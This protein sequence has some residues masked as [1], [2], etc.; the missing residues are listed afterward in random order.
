MRQGHRRALSTVRQ[1][2]RLFVLRDRV[3]KFAGS[4][5]AEAQ[6][7]VLRPIVSVQK[8]ASPAC[9]NQFRVIA[10]QIIC[11]GFGPGRTETVVQ[12]V[13]FRDLCKSFVPPANE[14][15]KDGAILMRAAVT[16][17]QSN[18]TAELSVGSVEIPVKLPTQQA[19]GVVGFADAVVQFQRFGYRLLSRLVGAILFQSS[20]KR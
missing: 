16:R 4:F 20:G 3:P 18:S 1:L 14:S 5:V 11:C 13:D 7:V 12:L 6:E 17:C 15:Q 8:K 9:L 10:Q 2:K 19:E